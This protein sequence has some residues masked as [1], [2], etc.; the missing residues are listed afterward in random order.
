MLDESKWSD[1][2]L[3]IFGERK[4]TVKFLKEFLRCY[5]CITLCHTYVAMSEHLAYRFYWHSLLKR[6]KRGKGVSCRM[7]GKWKRDTRTSRR[8]FKYDW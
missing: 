4:K 2:Q 6:D 8:A 7:C 3:H 5:L 1:S